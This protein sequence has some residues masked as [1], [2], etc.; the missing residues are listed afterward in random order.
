MCVCVYVRERGRERGFC[1]HVV[2][3]CLFYFFD[4]TFSFFLR[5]LQPLGSY[6]EG[7]E[8][9]HLR[10]QVPALPSLLAHKSA[11]PALSPR[12]PTAPPPHPL[13]KR[14]GGGQGYARH[15]GGEGGAP[16]GLQGEGHVRHPPHPQGE[17]ARL[18]AGD[19]D[20]RE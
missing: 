17:R 11:L 5:A 16:H 1:A 18:L 8:R 4:V 6:Q 19:H 15:L 14:P 10:T 3:A 7:P 12:P 13:P 20:S 2:C 9:R